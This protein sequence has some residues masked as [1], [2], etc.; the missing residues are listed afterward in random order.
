MH[1]LTR[2]GLALLGLT[3]VSTP[4]RAGDPRALAD[5]MRAAATDRKGHARMAA[6]QRARQDDSA[7]RRFVDAHLDIYCG[8]SKGVP[9]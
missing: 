5:A 2:M 8:L 4:S 6:A 9:A 3:L 7:Y 1:S